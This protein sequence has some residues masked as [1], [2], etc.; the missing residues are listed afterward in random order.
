MLTSQVKIMALEITQYQI[1][2]LFAFFGLVLGYILAV[3]VNRRQRN[4]GRTRGS[5]GPARA[6]IVS[7]PTPLS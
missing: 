5:R 7:S 3:L 2:L 4:N 1:L 6:R